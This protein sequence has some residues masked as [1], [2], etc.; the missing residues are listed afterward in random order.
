MDA[1][2]RCRRREISLTLSR[3]FSRFN[4]RANSGKNLVRLIEK[5][6]AS[7]VIVQRRKISAWERGKAVWKPSVACFVTGLAGIYEL[8]LVNE[9]V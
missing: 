5:Q 4:L 7:L 2:L 1:V 3:R 8:K 9:I 6:N